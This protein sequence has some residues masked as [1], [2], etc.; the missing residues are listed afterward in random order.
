MAAAVPRLSRDPARGAVSPQPSVLCLQRAPIFSTIFR[1]KCPETAP[2]ARFFCLFRLS[3]AT[4][5]PNFCFVARLCSRSL[6]RVLSRY[7]AALSRGC[8]ANRS[9]PH[10]WTF[11]TKSRKKKRPLRGRRS[12]WKMKKSDEVRAPQARGRSGRPVQRAR[13]TSRFWLTAPHL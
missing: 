1:Q 2:Q 5:S 3:G 11:S 10:P 7:A 6:Q 13:P 12:S 9:F 4:I 8:V